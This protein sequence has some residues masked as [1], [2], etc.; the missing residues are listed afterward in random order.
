MLLL[1]PNFGS[2]FEILCG[3]V[4]SRVGFSVSPFAA[5]N[6][7]DSKSSKNYD[8][9]THDFLELL[10]GLEQSR[11]LCASDLPSAFMS[12]ERGRAALAALRPPVYARLDLARAR[13]S[14]AAQSSNPDEP[15]RFPCQHGE[16]YV[17]RGGHALDLGLLKHLSIGAVLNCAPSVCA[18]P[19]GKYDKV[20]LAIRE[21]TSW[22][23]YAADSFCVVFAGRN[24]LHGNRCA[25]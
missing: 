17:G 9:K 15:S 12:A 6:D 10:W 11:Q 2:F 25:G 24:L 18:D 5:S 22:T 19:V 14:L 23:C 16:I 13:T 4:F 20:R 3:S 7:C 1:L 21:H 8:D